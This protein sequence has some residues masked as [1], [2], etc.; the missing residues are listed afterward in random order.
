[1]AIGACVAALEVDLIKPREKLAS[2]SKKCLS[3]IAMIGSFKHCAIPGG[4]LGINDSIVERR[5]VFACCNVT[6]AIGVR[7]VEHWIALPVERRHRPDL[8]NDSLLAQ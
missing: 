6:Q 2:T 8:Q 1:M 5:P 4:V 3:G 7:A